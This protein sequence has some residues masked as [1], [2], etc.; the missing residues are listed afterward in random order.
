M[1][2]GLDNLTL[3]QCASAELII[4]HLKLGFIVV[5]HFPTFRDST[6]TV[7]FTTYFALGKI[8]NK[9]RITIESTVYMVVSYRPKF[10]LNCSFGG[11]GGGGGGV[12]RGIRVPTVGTQ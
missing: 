11:G 4:I 5:D 7:L 3:F 8:N 10:P 2:I 1:E 6:P 12:G 9:F